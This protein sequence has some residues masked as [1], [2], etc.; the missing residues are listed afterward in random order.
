MQVPDPVRLR[1]GAPPAGHPGGGREGDP[2]IW[3]ARP[4]P[5]RPFPVRLFPMRLSAVCS[6]PVCLA[7]GAALLAG[8]GAGGGTAPAPAADRPPAYRLPGRTVRTLGWR[9]D[10]ER[11]ALT[12]QLEFVEPTGPRRRWLVLAP[13]TDSLW[14]GFTASIGDSARPRYGVSMAWRLDDFNRL[15][16]AEWTPA[17]SL[18]MDRY[19]VDGTL[20]EEYRLNRGPA[21]VFRL[22]GPFDLEA[23][24]PTQW[25]AEPGSLAGSPLAARF[26]DFFRLALT[27]TD[28]PEA[29][30]LAA[31]LWECPSADWF[32]GRAGAAGQAFP[33][34]ADP[35]RARLLRA[36]CRS[37]GGCPVVACW[38]VRGVHPLCAGCRP[39]R[40]FCRFLRLVL[41]WPGIGTALAATSP[42]PRPSRIPS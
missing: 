32:R 40:G 39:E 29:A 31:F 35:P 13:F 8:C 1:A 34:P 26:H 36:L 42:P 14:T 19:F 20:R 41:G 18:A 7:A 11:G 33:G 38:T 4:F 22:H 37:G 30:R 10:P 27:L 25:R 9:V 21:H 24:E 15:S 16:A 2:V 3:T 5:A 12:V 17:E 23:P 6:A 28:N